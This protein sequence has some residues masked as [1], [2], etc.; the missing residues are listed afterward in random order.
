MYTNETKDDQSLDELKTKLESL[1]YEDRL[2]VAYQLKV[3]KESDR[4]KEWS[5]FLVDWLDSNEIVNDHASGS[6][7]SA[8][9]IAMANTAAVILRTSLEAQ[10]RAELQSQDA[11]TQW[12]VQL[13]DAMSDL[14]TDLETNAAQ[15]ASLM[16]QYQAC[17]SGRRAGIEYQDEQGTPVIYEVTSDDKETEG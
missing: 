6:S 17:L 7:D 14:A 13:T 1:S 2:R 8:P 4:I 15:M 9:V 3:T 11:S 10:T 5:L 16:S 12:A